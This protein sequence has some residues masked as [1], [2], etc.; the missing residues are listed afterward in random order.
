M[1]TQLED[2]RLRGRNWMWNKKAA[3]RRHATMDEMIH[4]HIVQ[5]LFIPGL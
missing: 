1:H 3:S 4:H 2:T 5:V